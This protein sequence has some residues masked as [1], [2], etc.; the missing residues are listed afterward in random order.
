MQEVRRRT[1]VLQQHKIGYNH[2]LY[3]T[4]LYRVPASSLD[5]SFLQPE[6]LTDIGQES[7]RRPIRLTHVLN[8]D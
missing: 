2:L 4:T 5:F 3:L 8:F 7:K 6:L 1:G